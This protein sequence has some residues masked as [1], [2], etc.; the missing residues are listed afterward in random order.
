M[1]TETNDTEHAYSG[2]ESWAIPITPV[3]PRS[4][5]VVDGAPEPQAY[6]ATGNPM[7]TKPAAELVP[8]TD[9]ELRKATAQQAIQLARTVMFLLQSFKK[10]PKT[11]AAGL[12]TALATIAVLVWPDIPPGVETAIA[13]GGSI[14][15][16]VLG[17]L[18]RDK[19]PAPQPPTKS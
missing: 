18:A 11:S 14:I 2:S 4:V 8:F 15:T 6:L 7:P 5:P 19:A 9:E 10:N 17:A 1:S 3:E 16:A 13:I 12:A